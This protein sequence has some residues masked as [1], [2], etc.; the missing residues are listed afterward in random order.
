MCLYLAVDRLVVFGV[1]LV[2]KDQTD[3]LERRMS[4]RDERLL[5]PTPGPCRAKWSAGGATF[6]CTLRE[7][8]AGKH[9]LEEVRNL[10]DSVEK[11]Q[12]IRSH[13]RPGNPR[14]R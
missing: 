14:P 5:A 12:R 4:K 8:H 9:D 13:R 7:G 10:A 2:Q 6:G 1:V 11:R 3:Q